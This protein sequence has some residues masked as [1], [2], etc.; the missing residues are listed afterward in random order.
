MQFSLP[1]STD[2]FVGGSKGRG[3]EAEREVNNVNVSVN[4]NA[5]ERKT[6]TGS[7]TRRARILQATSGE[8]S[9]VWRSPG[10]T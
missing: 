7:T 10:L 6:T 8:A 4:A 9:L 2:L 1:N 5:N 3:G